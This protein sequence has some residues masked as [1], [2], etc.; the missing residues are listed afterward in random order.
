[1]KISELIEALERFKT[2]HGDLE[3]RG[4]N[5]IYGLHAIDSV[6]LANDPWELQYD[7]N[8]IKGPIAVI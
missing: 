1:M 5:D 6:D 2:K 3:V 7:G 4:S 8:P